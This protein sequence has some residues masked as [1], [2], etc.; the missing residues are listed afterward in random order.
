MDTPNTPKLGNQLC[1]PLYVIAKEITGLYRPFLDELDITYPQ[2]L[3]MLVLWEYQ[4]MNVKEI[5]KLLNLDSGTL[6]PLLKRLETKQLVLR[7]RSKKDERIVEISLTEK[8]ERYK[9]KAFCIPDKLISKINLNQDEK[10]QFKQLIN[11]ISKS[12][13]L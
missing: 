6:T 8:G 9:E 10:T 11:K 2:Y 4:K 5:G 13:K 12:L 7:E 3:V 1:F